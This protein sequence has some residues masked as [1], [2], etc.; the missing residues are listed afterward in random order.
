VVSVA[1]AK[2]LIFHVWDG[3]KVL[4]NSEDLLFSVPLDVALIDPTWK[5]LCHRCVFEIID[6]Q[7]A[8]GWF[9]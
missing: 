3:S 8:V 5:Y 1:T 4:C 2:E 7:K 6:F 9:L